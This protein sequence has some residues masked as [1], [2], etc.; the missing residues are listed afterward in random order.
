MPDKKRS[1]DSVKEQ[2]EELSDELKS[3]IPPEVL[4]VDQSISPDELKEK[5][6]NLH[7]E[8]TEKTMG[9]KID[10]VEYLLVKEEDVAPGFLQ[11]IRI[12]RNPSLPSQPLDL[13]KLLGHPPDQEG[14]P[15]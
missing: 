4:K 1:K 11:Q 7:A 12:Q 13:R 2:K 3:L 5:F 14:L 10:N 6:P 15:G 9:V 8:I